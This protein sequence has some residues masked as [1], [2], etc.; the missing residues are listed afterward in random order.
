MEIAAQ[1]MKVSI[2]PTVTTDDYDEYRRQIEQAAEYATR[3]HIDL[4]DGIFTRQLTAIEDVWWP[5]GVRAD[6][7]VMFQEPFLHVPAIVALQPQLVIVHAEADGD[8]M[9]F[10]REM[11]RHGIEAGVSLL[12]ETMPDSIAAA[13]EL[14]DHVLIFSGDLGHFGGK[15]DLSLLKKVERLRELKPSL[16]IG[17]DGG[18]NAENARELVAGGVDVLNCGGYLH[19]DNP[20]AAYDS[21]K[22]LLETT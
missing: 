5:G 13:L 10:A 9:A 22:D 15:A 20:S 14:V 18:V 3:L 11:H 4:G 16:E 12:P 2:C 7:H 8:Y 19:G 1:K 21:L 17:W 6:L